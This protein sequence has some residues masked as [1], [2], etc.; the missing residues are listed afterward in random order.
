MKQV[1]LH[2]RLFSS[3]SKLFGVSFA[4]TMVAVAAFMIYFV[5][6]TTVKNQKI[7]AQNITE[8][9]ESYFMDINDFSAGLANSDKFKEAALIRI[10]EN[11]HDGAI[12]NASMMEIY[13]EAYKMFEKGYQIG[14]Y[15]RNGTYMWL[16]DQIA[17]GK[18]AC[19]DHTHV[20]YENYENLG[21]PAIFLLENN[22]TLETLPGAQQSRYTHEPTLVLARS[23]NRHNIVNK[24]QGML[25]IHVPYEDFVAVVEKALGTTEQD[26]L[27]LVISNDRNQV[28][29]G[30][31]APKEQGEYDWVQKGGDMVMQK[32]ILMHH[33]TLTYTIPQM[34]YYKNLIVL[35]L[36]IFIVFISVLGL[37]TLNVYHVS[38]TITK[39]IAAISNQLQSSVMVEQKKLT[40]VDTDI[41]ELDLMAEAVKHLQKRLQETMEQM[42]QSKTAAL[43][44]QLLALQSQMQ[45]HFLYNTLAVVSS[46]SSQGKHEN[47]SRICTNLS[48]MLRYTSS[49]NEAGVKL[50]DEIMF[51]NSYCTIMKERFPESKLHVDIPL[52][53]ANIRTPQMILQPL[54]EN[55]YKYAGIQNVE[56]WIKGRKTEAS[57]EIT[58]CDNG[59]GFQKEKIQEIME[60]CMEVRNGKNALMTKIDGMGLVNIYARLNL[61]Y[62]GQFVFQIVPGEGIT[63]GGKIL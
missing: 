61:F 58:V 53:M 13:Q 28:L 32:H 11:L 22:Q 59:A 25:E 34:E 31:Y 41:Y 55:A 24:P 26:Q 19:S 49:E 51:L 14:L 21:A 12:Q 7:M 52:G 44:S 16:S 17:V 2:K 29:Y 27:S 8:T 46:L 60:R 20:C 40:K 23:I 45:P 42:V 33:L 30:A 50:H 37:V 47:V 3:F 18:T 9:I 39:P 54:C 35:L 1:Q 63:I 6:N 36:L 43:Q 56:I 4:L 62:H 38:R 57:W 5:Q 10:P 15:T 48:K